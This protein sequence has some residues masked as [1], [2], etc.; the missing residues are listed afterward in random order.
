MATSVHHTQRE[1]HK[2]IFLPIEYICDMMKMCF[3]PEHDRIIA[4]LNSKLPQ[5]LIFKE[6]NAE[7]DPGGVGKKW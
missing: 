7:A 1:I 4:D 5:S 2:L 3:S 6:L